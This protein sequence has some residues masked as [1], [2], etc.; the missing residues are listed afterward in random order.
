MT[1]EIKEIHE[2]LNDEN[3]ASCKFMCNCETEYG[4]N[5]G[6]VETYGKLCYMEGMISFAKANGLLAS[7]NH[8]EKVLSDYVESLER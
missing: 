5:V 7:V 4:W 1:E 6:D 8:W 2:D 3:A